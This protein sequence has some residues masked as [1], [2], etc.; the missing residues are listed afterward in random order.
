MQE[1]MIRELPKSGQ[2]KLKR[3]AFRDRET[4]K[5]TYEYGNSRPEAWQNL[6]NAASDGDVGLAEDLFYEV[7]KDVKSTN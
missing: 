6:A 7:G 4:G 5:M 2:N 3:F 1:R